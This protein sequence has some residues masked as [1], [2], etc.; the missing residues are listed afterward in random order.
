MI[1]EPFNSRQLQDLGS[2]ILFAVNENAESIVQITFPSP[3]QCSQNTSVTPD[4][5]GCAIWSIRSNN[6]RDHEMPIWLAR[7]VNF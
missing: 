6:G 7:F 1:D 3:V 4:V 2:K 5:I